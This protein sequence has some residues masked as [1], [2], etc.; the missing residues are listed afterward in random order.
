[1]SRSSDGTAG[2]FTSVPAIVPI[3]IRPGADGVRHLRPIIV[4]GAMGIVLRCAE[5]MIVIRPA[6]LLAGSMRGAGTAGEMLAIGL[7]CA[8][9]IVKAAGDTIR[10]SHR[11]T[12][13]PAGVTGIGIR[14]EGNDALNLNYKLYR[15]FRAASV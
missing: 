9:G 6:L 4:R 10:P 11:M 3:R 2:V 14:R 8:G 13:N 5:T 12:P 7:T 1:M 15:A